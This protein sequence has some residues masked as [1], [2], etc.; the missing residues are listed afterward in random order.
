MRNNHSKMIPMVIE[1]VNKSDISSIKHIVSEVLKII[2]DERSSAK[3]LKDII[4][5][6]APLCARLLKLAN[7]AYYG[8][9][10]KISDIQEA[11]VCI[12]FDAVKELAL[13]QK[14]C[15][16]FMSEQTR[17]GYSR[18]SLWRHSLAV[19]ICSKMIYRR[20]FREHG[21][22]IYVAGL[23]HD[24]GIIIEDQFFPEL[25]DEALRGAAQEKRNLYEVEI[26][27]LGINHPQIA[28]VVSENWGFPDELI[29]AIAFHHQPDKAD[30]EFERF[31]RTV[32]LANYV[33]QREKI[34]YVDTHVRDVN[35][36]HECLSRLKIKEEA[37]DI[38][39]KDL[40][41][42]LRRMDEIGRCAA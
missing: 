30:A 29:Q 32:Y 8:Y 26:Q 2:K 36:F 17:E 3:D 27:T 34:G 24:I 7:S 5:R 13:S 31:V 12:G 9:S 40:K 20:E 14:V 25:F 39:V 6:D 15:E 16:L 11:I 37:I 38:I 4:E 22:D 21:N 33:C 10:K 42:E 18:W 41:E 35:E 23:L 28:K 19:A 1:L